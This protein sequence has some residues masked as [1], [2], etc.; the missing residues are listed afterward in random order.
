MESHEHQMKLQ[1]PLLYATLSSEEMSAV[2]LAG[3]FVEVMASGV[4]LA[5][6]VVLQRFQD[7][8]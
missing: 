7:I 8:S 2:K 5:T 1:E 4:P 3:A 6:V